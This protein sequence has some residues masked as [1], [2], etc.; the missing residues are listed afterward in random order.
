M[1][2]IKNNHPDIEIF[3]DSK[4][5]IPHFVIQEKVITLKGGFNG[6]R[7]WRKNRKNKKG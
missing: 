1:N 6:T 2:N 5:G 3:V 7:N 4:K